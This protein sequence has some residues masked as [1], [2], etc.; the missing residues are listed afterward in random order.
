MN[1]KPVTRRQINDALIRCGNNVNRQK[2]PLSSWR[3]Q[4]AE[5]KLLQARS[6][7]DHRQEH[8]EPLLDLLNWLTAQER[9]ML[10]Q[11]GETSLDISYRGYLNGR[12]DSYRHAIDHIKE[13]LQ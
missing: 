13:Q 9:E 11:L 10:H 3:W 6:I 7:F 2:V 5:G 12:H 8:N 4:R 1:H